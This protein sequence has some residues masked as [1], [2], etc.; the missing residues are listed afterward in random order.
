MRLGI[1]TFVDDEGGYTTIAV[2][3][4]LLVSLA[5]V[6]GAAN[7]EWLSSRSADVQTVADATAMA[8]ADTVSGFVTVAT[9]L[10]AC[11]LSLGLAGV[12]I[13]GAGLV[14]CAIP[15]L[16]AAGAKVITIGR[17]LL[18]ARREFAQRAAEGLQ[19]LESTL[20]LL[21]VMNSASTV[22]ANSQG[23]VGYTGCAI[24]FPQE[25]QS[26]FSSLLDG[27]DGKEIE[28]DAE[29]LQD[30]TDRAE[31]A[32]KRAD[33]ARQE[34]WRADCG[35]TPYC[36]QERASTLAGL[37]GSANPYYP[38]PDS[39]TFGVALE[40]ARSYY[41]QRLVIEGP[42]W[43]G[44]DALTDSCARTAFYEYASSE[45]DSG[46]Y[47]EDPEGFVD[48]ELPDLPHNTDEVKQTRLYTDARWPCT[49][50]KSGVTL[51][52]TL[53]CPGAT[54]AV[55]GSASLADLDA[56]SVRLCPVCRM[57]IVDVG[58]VGA[59]STSIE[60][61][62]EHYWKRVVAASHD[63]QQARNEQAQAEKD[64]REAAEKGS[65]DFDKAIDALSIPRPRLCPPGAWGCVAVVARGSG[66]M[67]PAELA[68][69]F[70][71]GQSLPAGAAVSAA[72][73][74]TDEQTAENNV[75][76]SFFDGISSNGESD[77]SVGGVLDGVCELWGRLLVS[78]GSTVERPSDIAGDTFD[79]VD[80]GAGGK[81]SWWLRRRLAE[82]VAAAGLEPCDLSLRKP[83]LANSQDVLSQAGLDGLSTARD[84]IERLPSGGGP[85]ELAGALG[86]QLANEVGGTVVTVAELPI[87]GT[88]ITIPLTV[89]LAE[90]EKAS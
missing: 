68:S 49:K 37:N 44:I 12:F 14:I 89:D 72:T 83:V 45:V 74:A 55:V 11:V 10:D 82:V 24:P 30:A 13:L 50:E 47:S 66:T 60:N 27:V 65:D 51:H 3:V 16:R 23:S 84:L 33:A 80:G 29:E 5:L 32:K 85:E 90:L 1:S 56:G 36:M 4:A 28:D 61:G 57:D 31:E 17:D 41:R 22:S 87:P 21:I 26:D 42:E 19:K 70:S 79:S 34:G 52:S 64:A 9:V 77:V 25:S 75:L 76:S 46:H 40:R 7:A 38:T 73:L 20:P 53:A 43:D 8:G 54:G 59:A 48:M 81:L 18:N 6:F 58:K 15:G 35:D 62:F 39:W 88:S 71:S 78:Y 69:S 63:Y 86:Q 2:A 67:P